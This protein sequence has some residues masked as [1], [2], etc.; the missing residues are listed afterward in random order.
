MT[1]TEYKWEKMGNKSNN[2]SEGSGS[3]REKN[4]LSE[5]RFRKLVQEGS[6]LIAILTRQGEYIYASPNYSEYLGIGED[7]L[8]GKNAFEYIHQADLKR[9]NKEIERIDREGSVTTTPYRFLHKDGSWRWME[10]TCVDLR[11]DPAIGGIVANSIDITESLYYQRLEKLEKRVLEQN[12]SGEPPEEFLKE[13]L[14]GLETLHDGMICSIM[15]VKDGRLLNL[16]SPSLSKGYLEK[17]EGVH[18]SATIGSCG[19]AAYKKEKVIVTDIQNDGRWEGYQELAAE[20]NLAACWSVPIMDSN[21]EVMVTFGVYSPVPKSPTGDELRTVHRVSQL[22]QLIFEN[23]KVL[24]DLK[25]SNERYEYVTHATSEAIWDFNPETGK[26]FWG[27]G[28]RTLFGYERETDETGISRWIDKVHPGDIGE[29]HGKV[30]AF[31]AGKLNRWN[32]EYRFRKKNGEI[33]HVRDKA[34]AIKDENGKIARV[35]GAM[36]DITKHKEEEQRLKLMES[37]VTNATDAILI[38]EAEPLDSPDGPRI[39]YV[40]EA[41]EKMTGYSESEV[42]GKTPRILQG[43]NSDFDALKRMGEKLRRWE[44][45]EVETINYKKN[46][47]EFW[48]QFLVNPVANQ[49]GIYTHWIAVER[50]VTERKNREQQQMLLADITREFSKAESLIP[51]LSGAVKHLCKLRNFELAEFWLIDRDEGILKRMSDVAL[52]EGA[53]EFRKLTGDVGAFSIGEG[54]PGKTWEKR[55]TLCWRDLGNKKEFVRSE[56]SKQAGLKTGYGIPVFDRTE[57]IGTLLIATE[58]ETGEGNLV[59]PMLEEVCRQIGP[60]IRRKRAEEELNRIFSFAPDIICVAGMDGYFKKINPA[61]TRLLGYSQEELLSRPIQSFT[62]PDDE[63]KTVG[64]INAI[65]RGTGKS[66]FENR[67]LTKDGNVVWL[68]WTTKVFEEEGTI[69]SVARDVTVQKNLE[70]LLDQANRLARIGSWEVEMDT[71]EIYWSQIIREIHEAAEAYEPKLEDGVSFY[72][73]GESREKIKDALDRA[74][75]Q[76]EPWDVELQIVTHKGNEKWVRAIGQPEMFN[77]KCV[78]LFG[79]FQDIDQRKKAE[80]AFKE[81]SRER[82]NILE[83]ISDAFYAVDENWKITYFNREAENLLNKKAEDVLGRSLWDAFAPAKETEIFRVYNEVMD[84]GIQQSLEF[85]YPPLE[86]WFDVSA[87][88][89]E[90]GISVYFKNINERKRQ[91]QEIVN[92]THQLDAIATFNSLL[93]QEEHWLNALKRSLKLFGKIYDADRVYFFEFHPSDATGEEAVT[94]KAEWVDESIDPQI[95]LDAHKDVPLGA[96]G[97]FMEDLRNRQMFNTAVDNI[98]DESFRNLLKEQQ[99]L[100]IL[101]VPVFADEQFRGFIG[102]DDCHSARPW[103]EE[104]A[105]FLKTIAINLASAIENADAKRAVQEA[106]DEKNTILES[107]DDAFFHV[108]KNWVVK[109]WNSKAEELLGTRRDEIVGKNLW[110]IYADAVSLDFYTQYHKAVEEQTSVQFEEYYPGTE[111]WFDVSA[112]PADNGLSVF[113]RDSTVRRKTI[114]KIRLSNERFTKVADA[115]KD[116]IWDWNV[117]TNTLFFGDGFRKLFG[118][119]PS[120]FGRDVKIWADHVHEDDR[121]EAFNSLLEAVESKD[122]SRWY[123]EYKFRKRNGDYAYVQ[124][125]G[126][127]IRN[128]EGEVTRVVGA[129]RDVTEQK[130]Y[131]ERLIELNRSLEEQTKELEISNAE[132]EQFAFVASHDLQEPLRM[133]SSF[134]TQLDKRYGEHLDER[135]RRYIHFATDGASRM[136]QII[137]DLLNYSRLNHIEVPLEDVDVEAV[138]TE[139]Q[140][141]LE[142]RLKDSGGVIKWEED[143]PVVKAAQGPLKQVFQNIISNG[144]KYQPEDH[145]P[146]IHIS[147]T[148]EEFSWHFMVSDNGIGIEESYTEKIFDIFQRLHSSDEYSGTG[149]GLSIC[150]KVVEQHGGEIWVESDGKT[151]STFHFTISKQNEAEE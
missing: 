90:N 85:Y 21:N 12:L 76:G 107:I 6:D 147:A 16:A 27:D 36:E 126:S 108:D 65:N 138:L 140:G 19:I 33:A 56:A 101:A 91:E 9:L 97:K 99:I 20:H 64:E 35:V 106:F 69:Y 55:E 72:K 117:K 94:M 82:M 51:A 48:I 5:Q 112:Y 120:E 68:S 89:S 141:M 42:V 105:G 43:P 75:K 128:S 50:D 104:E 37:V 102:F 74:I 109:Y 133:I 18:I 47:E 113:F 131:E 81:A 38:T 88:P 67:F 87:F 135:A 145:A 39:V 7:E 53:R 44:P 143:L 111:T 29:L 132:L 63:A 151:G 24:Q 130:I 66:Y 61:M 17:I 30:K 144:V 86:S 60:E 100:S 40:N 46:G 41:F 2:K 142:P 110:D 73:E 103:S 115:V 54:L 28:F 26:L 59:I 129:M 4:E 116:A 80:V 98:E 77:G 14:K 118:H 57:V 49:S 22:L 23:Q 150:K 58:N 52:T 31:M 95:G 3:V 123:T 127:I 79:S 136:R 70:D 149:M 84:S 15:R 134:L 25:S 92:K 13:F 119:N 78:R 93:I 45:A 34:I 11:D 146:E 62:H 122:Q 124:D 10:T 148:K 1:Y 71:N 137:L 96:L 32:H 83:S 125:S 139:I 121:E 8:V 114:E